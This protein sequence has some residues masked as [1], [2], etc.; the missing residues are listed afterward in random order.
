EPPLKDKIASRAFCRFFLSLSRVYSPSRV[1]PWCK[2]WRSCDHHALP[3]KPYPSFV[4]T[5]VSFSEGIAATPELWR[6]DQPGLCRH[7]R[8][9]SVPVCPDDTN[10][11]PRA[12]HVQR[13]SAGFRDGCAAKVEK[14]TLA[15]LDQRA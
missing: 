6:L 3:G 10:E 11:K 7:R 13:L 2:A 5:M 1:R 15:V 12:R 9:Q 4:T 8:S 14:I